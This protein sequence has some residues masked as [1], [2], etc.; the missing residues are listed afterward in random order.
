MNR[1]EMSL[2]INIQLCKPTGSLHIQLLRVIYTEGEWATFFVCFY[3]FKFAA[4]QPYYISES[5]I[6]NF[7]SGTLESA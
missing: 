1:G 2:Y 7:T 6:A 4:M 3:V 5:K